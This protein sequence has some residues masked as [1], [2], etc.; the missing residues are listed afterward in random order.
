MTIGSANPPPPSEGTGPGGE[1]DTAVPGGAA[2]APLTPPADVPPWLP[3]I[4]ARPSDD[5]PADAGQHWLWSQ[6]WT[7]YRWAV[8]MHS[9]EACRQ[10]QAQMRVALIDALDT[11]IGRVEAALA[12][13]R[14]ITR[15]EVV[16]AMSALVPVAIRST[17][18]NWTDEIV[19][20][21][22]VLWSKMQVPAP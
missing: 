15:A 20:V 1:I 11:A 7:N 4:P 10:G 14:Q 22:D 13:R 2:P 8:Q 5:A 9:D 6:H 18:H 16:L 3:A 19:K 12:N 21:A 17:E